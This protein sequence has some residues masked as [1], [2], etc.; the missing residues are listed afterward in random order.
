MSM[1]DSS[2]LTNNLFASMFDPRYQAE[3]KWT[4]AQVDCLLPVM[5]QKAKG[6]AAAAYCDSVK[7]A[8]SA[9]KALKELDEKD[10]ADVVTDAKDQIRKILSGKDIDE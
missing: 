7:Q 8:V 5:R 9:A 10:Y 3:K 6:E 1:L 4:E 2:P